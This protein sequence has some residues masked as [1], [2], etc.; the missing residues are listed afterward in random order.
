MLAWADP[1]RALACAVMTNGKPALYPELGRFY[2]LCQRI[3]TEAPKLEDYEPEFA[4]VDRL[5]YRIDRDD[6]RKPEPRRG[7]GDRRHLVR[8]RARIRASG[9]AGADRRAQRPRDHLRRARRRGP[10]AGGGTRGAR[11]RQGRRA[12]GLHAEPAR[13]RDRLPR[14]RLGGRSLHDGEPALHGDR[15]GPPAPRLR[16]QVPAHGAARS[17]RPRARRRT[18]PGSRRSS[19][20]ARARARRRSRSC[21]A[22]PAMPPRSRSTPAPTSRCC[23]TRAAPP[24]CPRA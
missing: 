7:P 21:S 10:G 23:P 18:R 8:P 22:I 12:R 2:G 17:S 15:A 19:S 24:D 11:L 5:A 3:T 20:S 16:R 9:Q 1:E 14:R 13:V 6:P 4:D